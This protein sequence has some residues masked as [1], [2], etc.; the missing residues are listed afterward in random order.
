VTPLEVVRIFEEI[1]G[2]KFD[3]QHVPEQALQG[4][5]AAAVDEF[6]KTFPA[7]MLHYA[8]GDEIDMSQTARAFPFKL[9]SVRE[10]ASRV[11][12]TPA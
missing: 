8:R 10:Y 1:G 2:R 11:L 9:T 3:V 12:A 5:Q 4:Q 6:Q 7:L